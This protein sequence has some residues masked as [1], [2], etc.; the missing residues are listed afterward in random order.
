LI[1]KLNAE[2]SV[3]TFVVSNKVAKKVKN[4]IVFKYVV[5]NQLIENKEPFNTLSSH[6]K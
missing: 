6:F 1:A 2:L 4:N 3:S 5:I